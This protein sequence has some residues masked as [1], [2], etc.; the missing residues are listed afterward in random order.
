MKT[1]DPIDRQA[2]IEAVEDIDWYHLNIKGEMVGGANSSE[3]QAWYKADDVYKVLEEVPSAQPEPQWIP[4]AE[5]PIEKGLMLVTYNDGDV[6]LIKQPTAY[7]R[8]DIVAW[9]PIESWRGAEHEADYR[10]E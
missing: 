9:M 2:A 8:S 10:K 4:V 1:M 3:H 6:D 7:R 5:K